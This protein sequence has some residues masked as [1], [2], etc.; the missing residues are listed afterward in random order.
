[1]MVLL[2]S[3]LN[4]RNISG[5]DRVAR[6]NLYPTAE[7]QG[8]TLPGTSSATAI[9]EMKKLAADILPSGFSYEWTDLSY[10]QVTVANAGLYVFPVCVL[11]VFL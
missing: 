5:P 10:Q 6:Y 11:F 8:D 7:L 4:F 2:G 9:E 3:V 1:D